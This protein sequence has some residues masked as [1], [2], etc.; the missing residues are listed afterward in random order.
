M[1]TPEIS[2]VIPTYNKAQYLALALAS[3]CHQDHDGF[4]LIIV[5]D[6]ST[7]GT[8]DVVRAYRDKLP[9]R[10]CRTSNRGRAAAR[11]QGTSI[12]AGRL[13]VFVDDD[14]VVMENFLQEHS[15]AQSSHSVVVGWQSGLLVDFPNR[16]DQH[17]P[18]ATL[19]ALCRDDERVAAALAEQTTIQ[20]LSASDL[21]VNLSVVP[22]YQIV[23][24]WE[25]YLS[26]FTDVFGD[27]LSDCPLA[28]SCGTTGNMSVERDL[29]ESV[30]GFDEAFRGWGIEDTE[31]LYRLSRT[32]ARTKLCRAARNFHAN[33]PKDA[34]LKRVDWSR[35][36]S[37]FLDKH[38]NLEVSM[39]IHTETGNISRLEACQVLRQAKEQ[40]GSALIDML[41]CLLIASAERILQRGAA[42]EPT[43][44]Q[45]SR[46]QPG[47]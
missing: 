2:V 35:N 16:G 43:N 11:N 6:G 46:T 22:K 3:W 4:E 9:I 31:L 27:E 36:A 32:G 42:W 40:P 38:R 29:L 26:L 1:S 41:E 17:I 21:A 28:W 24:P 44:G 23:D 10:Y 37:I 39:Y 33:H 15:A 30:G 19:A 8:P 25:P 12:A 34:A 5:D 47:D 7:D 45:L 20:T 18:P 14:R 13:V